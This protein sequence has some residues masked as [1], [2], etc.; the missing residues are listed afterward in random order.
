MSTMR[1]L[2]GTGPATTQSTESTD[3]FPRLLR[4]ERI[5]PTAL[6]DGNE[7]QDLSERRGRR[8]ALGH[9]IAGT[10]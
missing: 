7:R 10:S 8:R 3:L 4:V 2:L 9:G 1:R 5:M 6:L